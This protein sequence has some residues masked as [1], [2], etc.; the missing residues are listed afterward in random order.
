MAPKT[1]QN[2]P[3][4]LEKQQLK[5]KILNI[6]EPMCIN[7]MKEKPENIA[8]YMINYLKNKYNYS[9]SLLKN[10]EKKELVKLKNDVQL[11]HDMDEHFYFVDSQVKAKKDIKIV[12]KRGKAPPKPKPRLPPDDIIPSDD[13]DLNN[14]DEIDTRLDDPDY[15]QSNSNPDFRRGILEN[16]IDNNQETKIKYH[17]K[18]PEIFEFIKIN[19]MKSPLFSELSMDTITKCINAMEEKNYNSFE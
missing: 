14:P 15:I 5:Q 13:E 4:L 9:S 18:S 19:L 17:N 11:F 7:L 3:E 6:C 10:E 16:L 8:S 12:E 1:E 2:N